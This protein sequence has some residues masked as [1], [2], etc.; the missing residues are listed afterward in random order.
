MCIRLSLSRRLDIDPTGVE[1]SY[2]GMVPPLATAETPT[3]L[4][5]RAPK[6]YT[7]AMLAQSA[8]FLVEDSRAQVWDA[9]VTNLIQRMNEASLSSRMASSPITMQVRGFGMSFGIPGFVYGEYVYGSQIYSY[10]PIRT[11]EDEIVVPPVW[12]PGGCQGL[13]T[14][15]GQLR[16][17]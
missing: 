11:W 3:P 12:A 2:Y 16:A 1:L 8:P 6:L 15:R 9:N 4:F 10:E 17:G 7:Y 13:H 14:R 5:M